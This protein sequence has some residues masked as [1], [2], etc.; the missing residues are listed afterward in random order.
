MSSTEASRRVGWAKAYAAEENLDV[1]AGDYNRARDDRENFKKGLS[2]LWGFTMAWFKSESPALYRDI[3]RQVLRYEATLDPRI[4]GA[5]A[6]WGTR[7]RR[8]NDANPTAAANFAENDAFMRDLKYRARA[9]LAAKYG[10]ETIQDMEALLERYQKA[11]GWPRRTF[12]QVTRASALA[13]IERGKT[14]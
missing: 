13:K 11:K 2:F 3:L 9:S 1:L 12:E 6:S 5:G 14:A 8:Q 7:A 4:M 10:F